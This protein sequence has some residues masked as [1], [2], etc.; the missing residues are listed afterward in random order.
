MATDATPAPR[1]GSPDERTQGAHQRVSSAH[2]SL[3]L[4]EAW[5]EPVPTIGRV[6]LSKL[7]AGHLDAEHQGAY[8]V[9]AAA[10]LSSQ[11]GTIGFLGG[12]QFDAIERFRAG[13]EAGA[14]AVKPDIKILAT[15]V[16][17]GIDGFSRDDLA[18]A[19]AERMYASGAD[20]IF[21][22]AGVAGFGVFEAAR[23]QTTTDRRL[24]A[25]GADSDQYLEVDP[26]LQPYVLTSMTKK[27]D[28]AVRTVIR[29][30]MDGG[31]ERATTV[32]TL[33]DGGL[34][35]SKTGGFLGD[36]VVATLENLKSD[37][38]AGNITVPIAP[39]GTLDPPVG[40]VAVTPVTVTFDGTTCRSDGPPTLRADEVIRVD[41][42]NTSTV[43]ALAFVQAEASPLVAVAVPAQGDGRNSGYA[44]VTG[45]GRYQI[46][47]TTPTFT[48]SQF[49]L[50]P[51]L[52]ATSP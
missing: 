52:A 47:C 40:V 35:Y 6:R 9:G 48:G 45:G 11:T 44:S 28:V 10:A 51:I 33:A 42:T 31:L 38:I 21:H 7:T 14:R 8:L 18:R 32:M 49:V 19:A 3:D 15:Y 25:I 37:I 1:S 16:S 41:L 46:F 26:R 22:A 2:L 39:T 43:D 13:Y 4:V 24:W 12:Y 27:F 5:A 29:D 30:F 50:G 36:D 34:D 23:A 20:V 17:L